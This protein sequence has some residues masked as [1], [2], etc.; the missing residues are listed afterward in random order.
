MTDEIEREIH[1]VNKKA[2]REIILPAD[3]VFIPGIIPTGSLGLDVGLNGGWPLGRICVL[4]GPKGVTKSTLTLTTIREAQKLG[5]NCLY[6]DAERSFTGEWAQRHGVDPTKMWVIQS[7]TIEN[8]LEHTRSLFEKKLIDVVIVDSISMIYSDKYFTEDNGA[9]GQQARATKELINKLDDWAPSALKLIISQ[10]TTNLS[11]F[12]PIS[13]PTGGNYLAHAASVNVKF[14]STSDD[15]KKG[16]VSIGDQSYERLI[17]MKINWEV[18]KSKVGFENIKGYYVWSPE[19]GIDVSSE[20][21][22]VGKQFG[23]IE[24]AGPMYRY[25]GNSYKG[26]AAFTTACEETGFVEEIRNEILKRAGI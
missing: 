4:W 17:S 15:K 20:I 21:L 9:I 10:M 14:T 1:L 18:T 26:K 6:I 22:E 8:I 16:T 2:E 11:G 13:M 3:K 24:Q 19:K 25:N 5:K 12:R 7:R 23:I